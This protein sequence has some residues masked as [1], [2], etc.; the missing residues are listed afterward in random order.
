MKERFEPKEDSFIFCKIVPILMLWSPESTELL[1]LPEAFV[2]T[3]DCLGAFPH[4]DLA[5]E[6]CCE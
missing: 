4:A 1:L 3:C 5:R 6:G 2:L